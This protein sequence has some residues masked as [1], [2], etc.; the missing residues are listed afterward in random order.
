[1]SL[2]LCGKT[3]SGKDT[4]LKNI[5]NL[6]PYYKKMV[7]YTTR[8]PRQGE[9]D[10]VTYHYVSDE[11]F[12]NKKSKGFFLETTEYEVATG[13]TWKYGS[14]KNEL[15]RNTV[16]IFNPEGWE[17]IKG[18][19]ETIGFY[20]KCCDYVISSRLEDRGDNIDEAAR[21]LLA[22]QRDFKGFESKIDFVLRNDLG[23]T[24]GELAEIIV[25]LYE[26]SIKSGMK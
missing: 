3:A 1:M 7:S 2:I 22:D 25:K 14:P 19:T 20:L 17:A 8:P 16:A 23:C 9:V 18:D 15:S 24:P 5:L 11:E 26:S 4:I 21:R 13:E 6:F 10:G 12:E